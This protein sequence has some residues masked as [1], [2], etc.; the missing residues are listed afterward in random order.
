MDQGIEDERIEQLL[1]IIAEYKAVLD[2]SYNEIFV[3]DGEGT[4][5][6]VSGACES[7][8]GVQE[9]DLVGRNVYQMELEGIMYPS[10]TVRV[11]KTRKQVTLLQDTSHGRKLLVTATPVINDEGKISRVISVSQDVTERNSLIERLRDMEECLNYYR[12]QLFSSGQWSGKRFP[13]VGNSVPM[14]EV[15]KMIAKAAAVDSTVLVLGES[16]VGKELVARH[17]H[18]LSSRRNGPFSKI[19][20]GAIPENLLESELF[21]YA[22]GAFTGASPLG[23]PGL[24]EMA[25]KGTLFLDEIGDMPLNLQVK[26][27]E[28]IQDRVFKRVG[29]VK[30]QEIDVRIIAATHQDLVAMV[31]EKRFRRD[32]YY[33]LNVIPI[34]IPPLR[35]RKE[36]IEILCNYFLDKFNL[37]NLKNSKLTSEALE[38]LRNY[39]WPGNVRELENLIERMVV[40]TDEEVI[41]GEQIK[42]VLKGE[43]FLANELSGK[44]IKVNR[45]MPWKEALGAL[46]D[47]LFSLAI[48][49]HKTTRAA[50]DFL[51]VHQSTVVRK[52]QRYQ[53]NE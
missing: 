29:D 47:Q 36:D 35:D 11:L 27:L 41:D 25:H 30:L 38:A 19:N 28:V 43:Q 24:I 1:E 16:G 10:A 46:E 21:G 52:L 26:L 48:K 44:G 32:L 34:N 31:K 17:I 20:C 3:T 23:K 51:G 37:Q 50:A 39:S 14:Q 22:K 53:E 42:V 7:F 45:L 12:E 8:C 40:L 33:R 5:I 6:R 9:K 13:M 2:S 18:V 49:E 15:R 4:V